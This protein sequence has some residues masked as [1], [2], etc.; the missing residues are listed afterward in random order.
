[1]KWITPGYAPATERV[2]KQLSI[3]GSCRRRMGQLP[4]ISSDFLFF[5]ETG[6]ML[7]GPII[8]SFSIT[9]ETTARQLAAFQMILQALTADT[10]SGTRIIAAVAL[11]KILFFF[12][13]HRLS[14]ELHQPC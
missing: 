5:H 14:P 7:E 8:S 9:G 6:E 11:L 2:W 1:M 4:P 13:L 12:A 10:L 3:L